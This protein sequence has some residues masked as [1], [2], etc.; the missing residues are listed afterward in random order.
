MTGGA[1]RVLK[2]TLASSFLV[3]ADCEAPGEALVAASKQQARGTGGGGGGVRAALQSVSMN[4]RTP[5]AQANKAARGDETCCA[6]LGSPGL[7]RR[8]YAL[9]KKFG[10]AAP[11]DA[12]AALA[13]VATPR[14][15]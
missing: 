15:V 1:R 7:D 10:V 4:V 11:T 9:L 5:V 2:A 14:R 8:A 12:A 13:V 3:A 6:V